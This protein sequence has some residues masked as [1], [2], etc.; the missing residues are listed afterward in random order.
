MFRRKKP[1]WQ[2]LISGLY[3]PPLLKFGAGYP[4]SDC[5]GGCGD[6]DEDT[7][8]GTPGNVPGNMLLTIPAST[9]APCVLCPGYA[10]D[11]VLPKHDTAECNWSANFT[12]E[13]E[14]YLFGTLISCNVAFLKILG[15]W[16]LFAYI[17]GICNTNGF[18][19]FVLEFS[20]V[21]NCSEFDEV[22][23]PFD[24]Y[25]PA[26]TCCDFTGTS[27]IVTAL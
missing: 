19:R 23:V 20:S 21:Q 5:C 27:A 22:V 14:C 15:V 18:N 1:E 2:K 24:G 17:S 7:C 25:G 6:C 10:G 9:A 26:P 16:T 12:F 11:Y 3:V 8:C 13:E 4:C